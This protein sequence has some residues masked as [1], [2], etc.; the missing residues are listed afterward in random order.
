MIPEVTDLQ[1]WVNIDTNA[2]GSNVPIN[3]FNKRSRELIKNYDEFGANEKLDEELIQYAEGT[4]IHSVEI[5]RGYGV[6]TSAPGYMDSSE[7]EVYKD[8]DEAG[9]RLKELAEEVWDNDENETENE[10]Y[11]KFVQDVDEWLDS[12]EEDP[13]EWMKPF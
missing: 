5:I 3:S 1:D 9:E 6:R 4:R 12:G 2:G 13:P 8:K 10:E 7:W 11:E